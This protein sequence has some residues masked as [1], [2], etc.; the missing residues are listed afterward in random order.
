MA[1]KKVILVG[2]EFCIRREALADEAITPG[3]LLE[4]TATGVQKHSG[5]ASN[6]QPLFAYERELTGDDI[7]TAYAADDTLLMAHCPPGTV[8][9]ALAGT[10]DVTALS[11]VESDGLGRL[12]DVQ[13]AAATAD[14]ARASVVGVALTAA[15][16]GARFKCEII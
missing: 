9:W 8:V 4:R 1:V 6:A 11:F 10:A 15:S 12:Q 3:H 2:E 5:A 13:T 7:D 16:A 14:T